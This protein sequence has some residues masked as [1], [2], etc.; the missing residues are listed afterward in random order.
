MNEFPKGF[1][2]GGAIAANQA[3][4]S[5]DVNGKGMSTADIQPYVPNAKPEELHFNIMDSTLLDQY[6]SG[7]FYYPK[8]NGVHFYKNYKKYI[9]AIADLHFSVLRLSIAWTRIFPNGNEE[10]PNQEGLAFYRHLFQYM[11]KKGIQPIVTISHYE[12]PLYLVEHYGG[13]VN[14]KVEEFFIN[15]AKTVLDCFYKDVKYW[16]VINQI[17]LFDRES[18]ASLGILKDKVDDY[19]NATYQALYYQFIASAKIKKYARSIDPSIKIGMMLADNL[20]SPYSCDPK[21]V[22]VN[23]ERNRMQYFFSDVL[24]RGFYPAYAKR[25]FKKNNIFFETYPSDLE[26]L[27]NNTADFLAVSY[28]WSNTVKYDPKSKDHYKVV[29]NP[30]LERNEW[31]WSIGPDGLYE[32]LSSYWDRYQVP[33]MVAENGLGFDDQLADDG[34][35]HDDY[36]ID[37]TK[38]HVE[39]VRDAISDGANVFAYCTWAPFD[40]VSAGTAEMKKRYGLI[41]VDYDNYGKG[42]GSLI[43]KDS[44]YWFKKVIDQSNK[45]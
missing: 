11:K 31:G 15:F 23:F 1:L 42:T 35:V 26:I 18:F 32:C 21:D 5:Y 3:E 27:K 22:R 10:E 33:L 41:Y 12:M 28:Y 13:W 14:K 45:E 43:P 8:R 2:W 36:R 6:Q 17:N 40:I 4:G 25:Y 29:K 7:D 37:Y 34:T 38:K 9:D 24:I 20:T 44:A 30:Y 39:A 19:T 16:I